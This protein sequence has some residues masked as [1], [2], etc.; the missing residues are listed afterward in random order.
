MPQ[1]ANKLDGALLLDLQRGLPLAP[2]PL[3]RIGEKLGLT[4]ADVLKRIRALF[5]QGI[6]RRFGA[7]FDA[8]SLG[9]QSTLCAADIP[10]RELEAAVARITP[11]P[12]ITHCYPRDGQPNLWFT[13][14]APAGDLAGELARVAAALGP[15]EVLNLPAL[16]KFKIEAVFDPG[17]PEDRPPD[18]QPARQLAAAPAE[19][20]APL[21]A[22]E[23]QVVRRLQGTIPVVEDPFAA[24]ARELDYGPEALLELLSRWKR[25]GII[26]RIGL[27]VRH[28]K[29]GFAA[30]SMC[31][32]RVPLD[33]IEAAGRAVA[34]NPHVTHCYERPAFAAFPFNLYAMIHAATGAEAGRIFERIGADAALPPGRMLWSVREFKKSSPMFFCEERDA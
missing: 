19:S 3:A 12:G 31:V 34:R 32:W 20:P 26:R 24:L 7:V 33:R 17:A 5:E 21:S 9:Y 18:S 1:P 29:L 11:H 6:A 25:A 13:L 23:R 28:Q 22:R 15:Y 14:T 10:E 8:Q 16:R 27:I 2:Q 4:E 30:N